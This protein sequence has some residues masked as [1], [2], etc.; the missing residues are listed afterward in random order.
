[1]EKILLS[2]IG[3]ND[4]YPFEKVG[5]I[6]TLLKDD[7]FDKLYIFYNDN[8]Y[9]KPASDILRY[10][11]INHPKLR[12]LY[13]PA[14]SLNP[15]NYSTVYP[16]MYS[17]VKHVLKDND[18]AQY[19]ISLSSGTPT[20]HTCWI[21]L[22]YGG[23]IDANLVQVS[24]ES[25]IQQ[26]HLDLDD[27]PQI[28]KVEAVKAEITRL[29]RENTQLK[30]Q[31]K[32]TDFHIIGESPEM[33][34]VKEQIQLLA[35]TDIPVFISGESGT[36][37]ELVA[38]ALHYNGARKNNPFV[39][40]NCGAIPANLFESEFFGHKKGAF[41]GAIA[42]R[43]GKFK[44][45]DKGTIFLDEI[46]DLPLEMQTKLLRVLQDGK[47]NV[48]GDSKEES[49]D[50]S[51]ISATNKD[52]HQMVND[53]KFRE[54]LFYRLVYAEISLPPL[55][56]RGSDKALIAR[57]ILT[58]L[59]QKYQQQKQLDDAALNKILNNDWYG[60]VRQLQNTLTTAFAYPGEVITAEQLNIINLQS[61]AERIAI[62]D[63][64]IDLDNEII[65]LYYRAALAKADNNAEKAAELLGL[66]P[67]TF[68]AR[69]RRLKK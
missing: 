41:T 43:I 15:T 20:M 21:F 29:S 8:Q 66:K 63:E 27:F 59:N 19:T 11:K 39:T 68:R 53:G 44:L 49:V 13:K 22:K 23:I 55:R 25:G 45:A 36:G 26:V 67:H 38:E 54:D 61:K 7:Q 17:A 64:G 12:V 2:F 37:K 9:L 32:R 62:P 60:N 48:V 50:V 42:D 35:D 46:G 52:I 10:C 56:E 51:I 3:N 40:V 31:L 14:L 57:H 65:P 28:N 4:C 24:R 33:L 30:H 34:R 16:A 5:A 58:N 69:L 47:F 1:M 18:N 6:L